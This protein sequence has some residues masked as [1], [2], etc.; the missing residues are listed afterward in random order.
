MPNLNPTGAG[1]RMLAAVHNTKAECLVAVGAAELNGLP[2]LD[3][4]LTSAIAF[5]DAGAAHQHKSTAPKD[6][7]FFISG[8][9]G[10]WDTTIAVGDG[11]RCIAS[12][13]MTGGVIHWG[14][15]G[16][17]T[18]TDRCKQVGG[19]AQGWTDHFLGYDLTSGLDPSGGG[20]TAVPIPQ[21][22]DN[23]IIYT[24]STASADG[25]IPKGGVF[26]QGD[27][28]R[29][30]VMSSYEKQA[31]DFWN[32]NGIPYR[33]AAWTGDQVRAVTMVSG[34]E[35]WN[36]DFTPTG[37]IIYADPAKADYPKVSGGS[38]TGGASAADVQAISDASDKNIAAM[39]TQLAGIL[40]TDVQTILTAIAPLA[41]TTDLAA[42]K[43]PTKV[44]FP[45]QTGTLSS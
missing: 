26:L 31:Y 28:G 36:A 33:L 12:D 35:Q 5:A 41:K 6:Y 38:S 42:I 21:G 37:K 20:G 43:F 32:A 29:L 4:A 1:A 14:L 13:Y 18:I 17:M 34:L 39:F 25:V 24:A 7:P 16:V 44:S 9:G 15:I 22:D 27:S 10:A 19:T 11:I 45:A 3:H 30:R 2:V 8:A 40:G 23:M